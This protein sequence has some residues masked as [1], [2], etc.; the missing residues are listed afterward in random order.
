VTEDSVTKE[1]VC[2]LYSDWIS[3]ANHQLPLA[4]INS[5]RSVNFLT[6]YIVESALRCR[7]KVKLYEDSDINS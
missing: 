7:N 4:T 3:P 6:D 5:S 2:R 1:W